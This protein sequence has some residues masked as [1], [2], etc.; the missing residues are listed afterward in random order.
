ME[1]QIARRLLHEA[2]NGADE[3]EGGGGGGRGGGGDGMDVDMEHIVDPAFLRMLLR[4]EARLP[5]SESFPMP[6]CRRCP[7]GCA[8]EVYCSQRCEA[9]AWDSHEKYLC[10]GGDGGGGG[11]GPG[12]R[13]GGYSQTLNPKP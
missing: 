9:N 6:A 1:H 4:G 2:G 11:S 12:S 3:E 7:G 10:G 8:R 5:G 13:A